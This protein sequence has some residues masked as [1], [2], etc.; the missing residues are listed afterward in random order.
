[1]ERVIKA[2]AGVTFSIVLTETGKGRL[3]GAARPAV[4]SRLYMSVFSFGSGEKGQLG[5]G[6]TGEYI[7]TAGKTAFDVEIEPGNVLGVR[8]ETYTY[9]VRV[10][11]VKGL[12]GKNIVQISCGQQHTVALD[13]DG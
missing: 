4:C 7:V 5:R 6:R 11:L 13:D 12:E 2:A 8:A 9:Y 1:M 10:V 3:L